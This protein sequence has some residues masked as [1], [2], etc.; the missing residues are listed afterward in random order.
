MTSE[1]TRIK[2]LDPFVGEWRTEIRFPDG[3]AGEASCTFEWALDGNFLIQ[4]SEVPVPEAP[5]AI[6]IIS[7]D[8]KSENYLQHYFDSRG[9]IRVYDMALTDGQW[10]L[11]R[12]SEDFSPLNFWQRYEGAWEDAGDTI[13]GHWLMNQEKDGN[14]ELD[15]DLDYVRVD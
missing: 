2:A 15:F 11:T 10:T 14:Y 13:R 7:L 1:D 8:P 5:D 4:R 3:T 12:E 6:S 9:V